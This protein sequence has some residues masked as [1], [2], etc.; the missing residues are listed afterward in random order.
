MDEQSKTTGVLGALLGLAVVG[1]L[2]L[3]N[4]SQ[5]AADPNPPPNPKADDQPQVRRGPPS[6][7]E[8]AR[9]MF[10]QYGTGVIHQVEQLVYDLQSQGRIDEA[11]HGTGSGPP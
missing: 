9:N 5:R 11:K 4:R 3:L 2:V 10:Q 1:G 6:P 8:I 7:N